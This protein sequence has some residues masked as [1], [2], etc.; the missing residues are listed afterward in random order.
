MSVVLAQ[1]T[2]MQVHSQLLLATIQNHFTSAYTVFGINDFCPT[3]FRKTRVLLLFLN[4][5]L[6]H[7]RF[8]FGIGLIL[9][10][11]KPA[12]ELE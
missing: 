3:L 11:G 1:S 2:A 6:F 9:L 10:Q 5:S 4:I 8:I 7:H 12:L